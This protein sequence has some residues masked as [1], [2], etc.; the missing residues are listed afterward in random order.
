MQSNELSKKLETEQIKRILKFVYFSLFY[1]NE[2]KCYCY[3]TV[4]MDDNFYLNEQIVIAI[5]YVAFQV[6]TVIVA[7]P[8]AVATTA[9]DTAPIFHQDLFCKD[10][11]K[12]FLM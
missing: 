3:K 12:G 1:Q 9:A 5:Y 2:V 4:N 7:T 8:A 11:S 6:P 10:D